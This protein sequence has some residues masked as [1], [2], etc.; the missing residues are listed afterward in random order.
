MID[1][2][3]IPVCRCLTNPYCDVY[4]SF[5]IPALWKCRRCGGW[6]RYLPLPP[7][8][9]DAVREYGFRGIIWKVRDLL[10]EEIL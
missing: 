10:A 1:L 9:R 2:D 4:P 5:K 7:S 8:W 3:S 6:L